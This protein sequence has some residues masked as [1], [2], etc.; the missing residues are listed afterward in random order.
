MTLPSNFAVFNN[1]MRNKGVLIHA[2]DASRKLTVHGMND[3]LY[4][5]DGFVALPCHDYQKQNY[6]YYA[7]ST[8][9]N[10]SSAQLTSQVLLVGCDASTELTITPTQEIQIP[11]DLV[12]GSNLPLSVPSGGSYTITLNRLQTFMFHSTLDLTGS[13]VVSNKPISFFSGHECADVPVGVAAC[14][15]LVEQ[16]PPTI[17]WGKRIL[18]C[19]VT[20]KNCWRTVQ[21]NN[22]GS[23]YDSRLLLL[24]IW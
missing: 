16:L 20:G 6:T 12:R 18:C 11:P 14:D 5:A 15:H 2:T 7:V 13:K 8:H 1:T 23:Y 4:T 19:S 17:T 9:F 3:A 22:I 21:N 10:R 24:L